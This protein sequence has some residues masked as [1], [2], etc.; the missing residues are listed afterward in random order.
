MS[1]SGKTD[2]K[3]SKEAFVSDTTG[4]TITHVNCISTVALVSTFFVYLVGLGLW[5]LKKCS[6]TLYCAIRFRLTSPNQ[7]NLVV[8]W[9]V[10][11]LPL[12]LSMTLFAEMPLFLCSM[13]L[14]P[15]GILFQLPRK[16]YDEPPLSPSVSRTPSF[17]A[18]SS[19][20]T[21]STSSTKS[22][23]VITQ[24]PSLTVYRAHMLLMTFLAILAVDFPA[25]PRSLAKCE[26]FG[27]SLVRV[28]VP[29]D[30]RARM[31]MGLAT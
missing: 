21:T 18:H 16:N 22:P 6:I 28:S 14:V 8:E 27:V 23:I 3:S 5:H 2:Y 25:F 26:T 9:M 17:N 19:G 29:L 10:L 13:L 4:S 11:V 20:T 30:L 12:L 1:S 15:S 24:L 31:F 7:T